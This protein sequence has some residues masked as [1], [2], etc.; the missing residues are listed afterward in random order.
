MRGVDGAPPLSKA[1]TGRRISLMLWAMVAF[2]AAL[3]SIAFIC[4]DSWFDF[5]HASP[6]VDPQGLLPRTGASWAMF[7][8]LQ[9]VAALRW[10]YEP[11]WLF[12][13][14]AIRA[15]D[16]ATDWTYLIFSTQLTPLGT[17]SLACASP[18]NLILVIVFWKYWRCASRSHQ[19]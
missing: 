7:A 4:P 13:I 8:V 9:M 16:V 5:F 1:G 15:S 18:L 3:A 19:A 12:A 17:V 6:Y 2:D 11:S 14:G 10:K